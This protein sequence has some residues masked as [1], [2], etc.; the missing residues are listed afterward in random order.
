MKILGLMGGMQWLSTIEYYRLINEGVNRRLGSM[1]SAKCIIYSVDFETVRPLTVVNDWDKFLDLV[2]EASEGLQ[3]AGAEGIIL[4]ANTAHI[5]ADRLQA[6][7]KVPVIH[8]VDHVAA[9]IKRQG[10]DQVSL[11]GT[12]YTMELDFF[13][14]RLKKHGIVATVPGKADRDFIQTSIFEELGKEV[15]L[16]ATKQRYLDIIGGLSNAGSQGCILGCTE[17][18]LIIKQADVSVPV[19]DTT[20]IHADA[21]V[22]FILS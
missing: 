17:I 6:K 21:A 12:R 2:I 14:D 8:L 15:F 3:K 10:M 19:F 1:H 20:A 18:P 5:V 7:L 13:K 9:E 22:S 16:P 4:C 11:L